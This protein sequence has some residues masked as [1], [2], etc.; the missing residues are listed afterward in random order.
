MNRYFGINSLILAS[1]LLPS[2]RFAPQTHLQFSPPPLPWFEFEEGQKDLK[3]SG[4]LLHL[5]G[6]VEDNDPNPPDMGGDV[7]VYGGGVSAFFRYAFRPHFAIDIGGTVIGAGGDVGSAA[8]M[9]MGMITIPVD[10][11]FQPIRTDNIALILFGGFNLSWLFLGI[12]IDTGGYS[13]EVDLSTA[14]RGPQ[15]G[16]QIAFKFPEWVISPFIMFSKLSGDVDF[17][18]KDNTGTDISGSWSVTAAT[19]MFYGIDIVYIPLDLTL[20]SIIQQVSSSGNNQG[21]RTYVLTVS[22]RFQLSEPSTKA[23][24]EKPTDKRRKTTGV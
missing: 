5:A 13:A 21:Y 2:T 8:T 7:S 17:D 9:R 19:A 14:M 12:D 20:S 23:R 24:E 3:I 22:Y 1:M 10:L 18:I 15:G 4:T 6:E 11:E 16:A